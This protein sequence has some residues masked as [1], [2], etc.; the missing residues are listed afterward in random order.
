[1]K[2]QKIKGCQVTDVYLFSTFNSYSLHQL[3]VSG[4]ISRMSSPKESRRE[5]PSLNTDYDEVKAA[6]NAKVLN[7]FHKRL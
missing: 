1:M 4:I 3:Q 5:L 7:L 6:K 2:R